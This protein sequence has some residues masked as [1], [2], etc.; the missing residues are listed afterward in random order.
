MNEM[1]SHAAKILNLKGEF[2]W[3]VNKAHRI[4]LHTSC[5]VEGHVGYDDRYYI[6]DTARAMPPA[7]PR[8]E[9]A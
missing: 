3:N 2:I 5:D 9:F 1:M 4:Q 6:V 8:K 7:T